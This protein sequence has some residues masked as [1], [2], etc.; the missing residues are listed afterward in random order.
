MKSSRVNNAIV[1]G[2]LRD[3]ESTATD[4]LFEWSLY[5]F[6]LLFI[7]SFIHSS[8]FSE[9]HEERERESEG[10]R[11]E[12]EQAALNVFCALLFFARVPPFPMR[13]SSEND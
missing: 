9:H 2:V 11:H 7:R 10:A 12:K 3:F 6:C 4:G 1:R 5:P 13:H 8:P